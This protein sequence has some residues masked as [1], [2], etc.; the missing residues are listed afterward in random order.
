[1]AGESRPALGGRNDCC[2]K[3]QG[4][5]QRR[6][7]SKKNKMSHHPKTTQKK[8]PRTDP[9]PV[10]Q[11]MRR[12]PAEASMTVS[13]YPPRSAVKPSLESCAR[14]R[15]R[16]IKKEKQ[17]A[18]AS[19]MHVVVVVLPRQ[20]HRQFELLAES[21]L[22]NIQDLRSFPASTAMRF[23][24]L[25]MSWAVGE[26]ASVRWGRRWP[27]HSLATSWDK[28][29]RQRTHGNHNDTGTQKLQ[30]YISLESCGLR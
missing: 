2:R 3:G 20:A 9:Q 22:N 25:V 4:Y 13:S 14:S 27:H 5:G 30:S 1:M 11:P 21:R 12:A 29:E 18:H 19:H 6:V 8:T 15:A 28:G 7:R 23:F 17:N 10:R 26:C 24:R 16:I